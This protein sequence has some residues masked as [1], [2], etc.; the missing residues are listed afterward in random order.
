MTRRSGRTTRMIQGLPDTGAIVVVAHPFMVGPMQQAIFQIRGSTILHLCRVV[1]VEGQSDIKSLAG[2][3]L[4]IHLDHT[5]AEHLDN[6][7]LEDLSVLQA[8]SRSGGILAEQAL[9]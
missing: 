2:C 8:M 6:M 4:P 5:A 9:G 7:T 3:N 1:V